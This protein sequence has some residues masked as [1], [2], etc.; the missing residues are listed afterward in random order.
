MTERAVSATDYERDDRATIAVFATI[1]STIIAA[2]YYLGRVGF[3]NPLQPIL[4]TLGLSLFVAVTPFVV[5]RLVTRGHYAEQ[6][7]WWRTQPALTVAAVALT[8]LAGMVVSPSGWNAA[9]VLS[10]AGFISALA[11]TA[12]WLRRGGIWP[13]LIFVTGAGI[14]AVWACGVAWSTRYKSPV[15]W[16]T[17][18]YKAD[19]HHDPLYY[20]SMANNMRTYSVPSTGLDGVPYTPYH[21]G[22]AWLNSQWAYLADIDVLAFY[23]LGPS[24][25]AIP[26]FFAAIL[27][28]V[29]E[30][31]K[32]TPSVVAGEARPLRSS[33]A[34]WLFLLAGT[35]G[36]IP[37]PG[38]D[39]MGIWNRHAMISESYVIGMPVFL[40]ALATSVAYWRHKIAS[41]RFGDLVFLLAFAP[42]MI[43]ITGFL[44]I[45]LMLL[46][47]ATGLVLLILGRLY[48][49]RWLAV[50]AVLCVAAAGVTFKLVS[51]PAQNQGLVPFA[52]LRFSG[53]ATDWWPYFILV[54]L[55]WSWLYV[56]LRLREEGLTDVG[57][58]RHAA[59]EGRITDVVVMATVAIAGF[60][61]GELVHIH[62]GSAIYFSDVQR[63]LAI[64][65]LMAATPRWVARLR[66]N[67]ETAGEG[68]RSFGGIRLSRVWLAALIIPIS[69]T[70][71][72]NVIRAPATALRANVALRRAFYAAAGAPAS[73]GARSLG[74]SGVL[75]AGLRRSPDYVL[76]SALRDLDRMPPALKQ[77]TL[78]FIPQSYNAFWRI[79][80]D[81]DG[82]CSFTPMIAPATSGLALLD[83]MPP[84]DCDLTDQYG[85]LRYRRR[86]TPQSPSET[87]APAL[88][89]R[90]RAKGFSRVIVLDGTSSGG[91]A[92]RPLECRS[93]QA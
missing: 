38:L 73:G 5:W 81:E 92:V 45:S 21:Y 75:A 11:A 26:L 35:I 10:L 59:V 69:I 32:S 61:P 3:E 55:F 67:R 30:V 87:T 51:V 13:N 56:Y 48:R 63:W 22:S 19:V 80:D 2:L 88:C 44:K 57:A 54:H 71:I 70:M 23:T 42:A 76:I 31:R 7:P 1:M 82:R 15:F 16:E 8:A 37:S 18:A 64:A 43:V 33:Y 41:P 27:L 36:V 91:V 52:Y 50:S 14:F 47:I 89:A 12:I 93:P 20:V 62:G 78:L 58:I 9:P 46:L 66:P 34:A 77:R 6:E 68:R 40:L 28:L 29:V 72:L 49:D 74:D 84:V 83:G 86:T 60:I 65:L 39:A 25:I 24:V 90:A 4:T 79:W 53:V 17:L 85:M